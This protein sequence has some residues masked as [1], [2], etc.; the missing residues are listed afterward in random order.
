MFLT[1]IAQFENFIQLI[2][3]SINATIAIKKYA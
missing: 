3:F 1:R 2:V